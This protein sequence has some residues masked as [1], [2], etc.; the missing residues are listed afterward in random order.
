MDKRK[1]SV[2]LGE[3]EQSIE[4]VEHIP[5]TT[6]AD[7]LFNFTDKREHL[8]ESLKNKMLSPRYNT[9]NVEY[10]DVEGLKSITIPMKCFCDINLHKISA[11]LGWYGC[12]GIAFPKAW[13]IKKRIQPVQYVNSESDLAKDLS[14]AFSNAMNLKSDKQSDFERIS[15]N[16]LLLQLMFSKPYSGL[17]RCAKDNGEE[18][19]KC[20]T[21]ES[22]WRFIPKVTEYNYPQ[23]IVNDAPFHP[24]AFVSWSNSMNGNK[25]VSLAFDY[26]DI[27]YIILKG[28]EDFEPII[29]TINSFHIEKIEKQ[30]LISKIIVWESSRG[31]F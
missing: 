25:N 31:D 17:A 14:L 20:F 10:L 23:V 1:P 5:S 12:F 11:H 21:D 29:E 16:Y 2:N 30:R 22:E 8:I 15:K 4:I 18:K 3:I 19:M 26:S 24:S 13:G 27:K 28:E 9:E 6:Q 7:T